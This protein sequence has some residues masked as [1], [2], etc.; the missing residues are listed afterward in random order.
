MKQ[1]KARKKLLAFFHG[2][3]RQ[4]PAQNQIIIGFP[5]L[6]AK[7]SLFLPDIQDILQ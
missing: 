6:L 2:K 3:S 1:L 5:L 4:P 7:K